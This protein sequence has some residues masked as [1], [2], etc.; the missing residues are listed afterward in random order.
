MPALLRHLRQ[1]VN[2]CL[3]LIRPPCD[4]TAAP[5]APTNNEKISLQNLMIEA[6]PT[7][8]RMNPSILEM[9]EG[10]PCLSFW[11]PVAVDLLFAAIQLLLCKIVVCILFLI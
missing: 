2:P 5:A 9:T 8:M 11:E 7:A 3:N 10:E 1:P 6:I 4:R